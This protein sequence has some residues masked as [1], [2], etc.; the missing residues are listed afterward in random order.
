M[1]SRVQVYCTLLRELRDAHQR[2]EKISQEAE[3]TM[4][5]RCQALWEAMTHEEQDMAE[6]LSTSPI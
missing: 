3:S 2:A 6:K 5:A 1:T 4:V